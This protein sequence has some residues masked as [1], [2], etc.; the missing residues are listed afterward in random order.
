[1]EELHL[2]LRAAVADELPSAIALRHRLHADSRLLG[3]EADTAAEVVRALKASSTI[4]RALC[5]GAACRNGTDDLFDTSSG[6]SG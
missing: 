5:L 4:G 3:D 6:T 2:K 1:M